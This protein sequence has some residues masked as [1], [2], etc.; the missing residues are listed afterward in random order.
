[1]TG[2][3]QLLEDWYAACAARGFDPCA[4]ARNWSA[5]E[6][7]VKQPHRDVDAELEQREG[8]DYRQQETER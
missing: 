3:S 5:A 2:R 1:M 8:W 4:M 6:R 7:L